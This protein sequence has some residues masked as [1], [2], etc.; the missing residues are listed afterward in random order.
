MNGRV[1]SQY[2]NYSMMVFKIVLPLPDFRPKLINDFH[3]RPSICRKWDFGNDLTLER[4]IA[5][6]TQ[7]H[8][9]KENIQN[10]FQV[11]QDWFR[12]VEKNLKHAFFCWK[13]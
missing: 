2:N 6:L 13:R 8:F 4:K 12:P 5:S 11:K 7:P 10:F 3:I 1:Q 9:V